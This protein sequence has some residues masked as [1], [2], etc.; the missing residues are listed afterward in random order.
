LTFGA[1][2]NSLVVN[3]IH[4]QLDRTRVDRILRPK[5]VK[6]LRAAVL[7]AKSAKKPLC[8]AG[9]RHAMGG[10]QFGTDMIL[11]DMTA[12]E[13]IVSFDPQ[14]GLVEVQGDLMTR[15]SRCMRGG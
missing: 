12:L 9:G 10:Q 13:Q 14:R 15:S 11:V 1:A 5:N 7:T 4:S 2:D 6:E 3:D 8:I